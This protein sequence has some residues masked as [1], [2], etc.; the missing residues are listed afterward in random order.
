[1]RTLVVAALVCAALL[2]G[3]ASATDAAPHRFSMRGAATITRD[4]PTLHGDTLSL[5]ADL[6]PS[7]AALSSS[8]VVQD[9]GQFT[10]MANAVAVSLVC[11]ND[12]IFRDDFDGDG[13]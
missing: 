7:N 10:L 4:S 5:R 11:Y 1:M 8:A 13:G 12:T 3:S 2:S 6:A 9:G